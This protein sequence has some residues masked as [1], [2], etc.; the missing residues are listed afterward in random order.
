MMVALYAAMAA[1][2]IGGLVMVA[3]TNP[4]EPPVVISMGRKI[5]SQEALIAAL[6]NK[7][8]AFENLA[9]EREKTLELYMQL[10]PELRP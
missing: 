8:E 2:G 9:N 5:E 10:R 6:Q 1:I 7:A 4:A 3:V